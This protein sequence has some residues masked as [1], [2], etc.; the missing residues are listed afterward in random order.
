MVTAVPAGRTTIILA[1]D[2]SVSMLQADIQPNRLAVAKKAALSFIE[3]QQSRSQIGIVAYAGIAQVVQPPTTDGEELEKAIQNLTTGR[4]TAVGEGI[5]TSINT[6]AE[7]NQNVV[8][9]SKSKNAPAPPPIPAG[10]HV[11]D[12]I[13]LLTDGANNTGFD[14]MEAAQQAADRGLR[15]YTIGYGTASG[16]VERGNNFQGGFN[17][18]ID[19][20]TMKKIAAL[21]GGEYFAASSAGELEKIFA[22]LPTVLFTRD[23]LTEISVYFAAFAALLAIISITLAQLWHPLP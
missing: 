20:P 17:R 5:L 10:T 14:P 8:A 12:I 22:S 2:V 13:V 11:P 3:K 15:V 21:T 6:I 19:E 1:L 23:E 7:F 4:G 16:A 9:S 18:G